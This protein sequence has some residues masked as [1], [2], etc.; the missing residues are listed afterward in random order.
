MREDDVTQEVDTVRKVGRLS[1]IEPKMDARCSQNPDQ[2]CFE[3]TS[4]V[5]QATALN[6]ALE[7]IRMAFLHLPVRAGVQN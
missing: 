6:L 2:G 4:I 1:D 3:Q 5:G 7:P